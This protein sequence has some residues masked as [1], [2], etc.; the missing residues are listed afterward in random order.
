M[1]LVLFHSMSLDL[2]MAVCLQTKLMLMTL[3][4]ALHHQCLPTRK[5]AASA[6]FIR[7]MAAFVPAP[8]RPGQH[9]GNPA[10]VTES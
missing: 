6:P 8:N 7:T 9:S 4:N 10:L 2:S 3:A 1:L 5:Q